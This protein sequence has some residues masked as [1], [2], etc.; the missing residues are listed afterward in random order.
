MSYLSH[1]ERLVR[2]QNAV[3]ARLGSPLSLKKKPVR[4]S[5]L[6]EPWRTYMILGYG[7]A[8]RGV[9]HVLEDEIRSRKAKKGGRDGTA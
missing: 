1:E 8:A 3:I 9:Q 6:E 4:I 5:D 7:I 2:I